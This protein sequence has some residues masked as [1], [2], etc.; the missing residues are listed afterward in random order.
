MR[1]NQL[2]LA[3]TILQSFSFWLACMVY[4]IEKAANWL[5]S[6][7]VTI[8]TEITRKGWGGIDLYITDPEGDLIQVVQYV[9]A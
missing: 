4:D 1:W 8:L 5:K 7:N 3:Q 2:F 9:Q 6:Q